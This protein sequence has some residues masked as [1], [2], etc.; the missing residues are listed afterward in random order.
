MPS[1]NNSVYYYTSTTYSALEVSFR[2][3][4]KL[5]STNKSFLF[6]K[7]VVLSKLYKY[8]T[9]SCTFAVFGPICKGNNEKFYNFP[10]ASNFFHTFKYEISVPVN[11]RVRTKKVD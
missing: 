10:K 3:N 1:N 8:S 6:F 2:S 11:F 5:L 7:F 9:G 4:R